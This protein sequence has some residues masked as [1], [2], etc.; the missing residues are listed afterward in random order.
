MC[1]KAATSSS[2]KNQVYHTRFSRR[3]G[4]ESYQKITICINNLESSYHGL[5][6]SWELVNLVSW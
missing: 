3:M 4:K 2:N 1:I 6:S 5:T